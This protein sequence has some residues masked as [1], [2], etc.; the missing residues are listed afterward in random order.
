MLA[1]RR[2]PRL[3]APIA[4]LA[5]RVWAPRD[6][7]RTSARP[8]RAVRFA[9]AGMGACPA[10]RP[11]RRPLARRAGS[12]AAMPRATRRLARG[13]RTR[14]AP[15]CSVSRLRAG[16]S[17][18]APHFVAP[19]VCLSGDT[20]GAAP[21]C[22]AA[23][24]R[25]PRRQRRCPLASGGGRLRTISIVR[26]SLQPRDMANDKSPHA[27]CF[28]VRGGLYTCARAQ[29]AWRTSDACARARV[30]CLEGCVRVDRDSLYV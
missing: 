6:G 10:S 20:A 5:A 7:R 18:S 4:P 28:S 23:G 19:C 11:S 2:P 3:G 17:A 13:A 22:E 29:A 24:T 14:G 15:A 21:T 12:R 8:P 30:W 16:L 1:T 26:S 27:S 25:R 9:L